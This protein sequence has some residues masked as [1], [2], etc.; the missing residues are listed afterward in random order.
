VELLILQWDEVSSSIPAD[1]EQL[2]AIVRATPEE[3]AAYWPIVAPLFPRVG[4]ARRQHRG[5]AMIRAKQE[6]RQQGFSRGANLTNKKRYGH[7]S[8][9]ET[10]R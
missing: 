6:E 8:G 3:W 5:L 1:E 2:R 7:P 10:T 9:K 4:R